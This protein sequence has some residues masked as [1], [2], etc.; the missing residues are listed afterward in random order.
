MALNVSKN[1][2]LTTLTAN[3]NTVRTISLPQSTTLTTLNVN[4]N[5]LTSIDVS[6]YTALTHLYLGENQLTALDVSKNTKLKE[7]ECHSNRFTTLDFSKNSSLRKISCYYNQIYDVPS[8]AQ[9]GES[10]VANLPNI[11]VNGFNHGDIL[12]TT[13]T[14][15]N[16]LTKDQVSIAISKGWSMK[17]DDGTTYLGTAI[18]AIE[19]VEVED[20]DN[21]DAPRYNL[22]GQPVDDTYRGIVI[23]NGKKVLTK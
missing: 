16:N 14:D 9:N 10:F 5:A 3:S 22:M 18:S 19:E 2:A 4:S 20:C 8:G 6:N 12:F 13:V 15:A 1:T 7:I 21:D 11:Y 23:Q 17:F